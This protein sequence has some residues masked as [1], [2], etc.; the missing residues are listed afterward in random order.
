MEVKSNDH[1]IW[2]KPY[3]VWVANIKH[4]KRPE[5][6]IEL[7]NRS[8][9]MEVDFLMIGKIQDHNYDYIINNDCDARR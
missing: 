8:N 7:A 6:F 3:V 9:N 5:C 4:P 1:F 2:D